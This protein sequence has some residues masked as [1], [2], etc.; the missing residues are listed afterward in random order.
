MIFGSSATAVAG[1]SNAS[2]IDGPVRKDG[3]SSF[4][5]PTGDGGKYARIGI[6][7]L[8][9]SDN[10]TA[11]YHN[12]K[13]S[14]N[15]NYS[16]PITKISDNEYWDLDRAGGS[17]TVTVTLYWED[18]KWSGIGNFSGLRIVHYGTSW[19][20]ES[21]SYSNTG[22]VSLTVVQTGSISVTNVSNF[23]PFS[24]GTT[25][26]TTNTLPIDLLSFN[27]IADDGVVLIDWK[28][29]SEENN[30]YFIVE[31]SKDRVSVEQ[32]AI[33]NGVGSSIDINEYSSIDNNPYSGNSYYRLTQVDY[34]GKSVSYDWVAV[35]VNKKEPQ[36]SVYPNPISANTALNVNFDNMIGKTEVL[37][38]SVDGKQVFITNQLIENSSQI[39][40]LNIDLPKGHYFMQIRNSDKAI[41]KKLVVL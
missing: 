17:V 22:A 10:F 29:A 19:T 1:G 25:N 18:S 16:S 34:D 37:I 26:N 20:A 27:A 40:K 28:T 6:S 38:Y 41:V 33:V 5:F 9:G 32:L 4:V 39:V 14:D 21:G 30:D 15:T 8:S 12:A 2:H 13:P 23:S 3:S 35:N 24:L 31:R 36:L 11:E 7:N